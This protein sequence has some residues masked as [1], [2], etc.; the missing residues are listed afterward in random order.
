MKIW[1]YLLY[2]VKVQMA[3]HQVLVSRRHIFEAS[4]N[5]S[6]TQNNKT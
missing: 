4:F 6:A 2:C 3:A 1:G 5:M